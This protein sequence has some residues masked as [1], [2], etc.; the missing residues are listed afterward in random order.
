MY[1]YLSNNSCWLSRYDNFSEAHTHENVEPTYSKLLNAKSCESV[2]T[3]SILNT[4]N[5]LK[6]LKFKNSEKVLLGHINI[7]SLRNKF[8][9]FIEMVRDK[10]D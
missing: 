2:S 3:K 4:N 8:E 10:V 1:I 6:N 5:V 9:L 7:N